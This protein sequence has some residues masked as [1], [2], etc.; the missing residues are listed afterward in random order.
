MVPTETL[1]CST[2]IHERNESLQQST[3]VYFTFKELTDL[4]ICYGRPMIG[5]LR[6]KWVPATEVEFQDLE[7]G[8]DLST[9]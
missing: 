7:M 9:H 5:A 2:E 6:Y 1:T 4:Y 3:V 8:T